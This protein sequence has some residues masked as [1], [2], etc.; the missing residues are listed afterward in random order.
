[1]GDTL[2]FD[3]DR[4]ARLHPQVALRGE[5]FGALAYHYGTRRLVFVKSPVL[6][7]VLEDLDRHGSVRAAVAAHASDDESGP[8]LAALAALHRSGVVDGR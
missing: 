8:L 3:V 2:A 1:M 5:S 4:P 7:D 6:V